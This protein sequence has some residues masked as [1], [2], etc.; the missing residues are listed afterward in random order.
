LIRIEPDWV[1]ELVGQWAGQDGVG[2]RHE[3]G[4]PNVSPMFSK[5][6]SAYVEDDVA[7]Y[8]HVELRAMVAA[9]DWLHLVHYE[10]WRALSREFRHWSRKTLVEKPGDRE[11]VLQA[12]RL[13]EKYIDEVLG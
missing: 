11:L 12:G 6:V 10:H 8:S 2:A 3:L 7:G 13:L 1:G 9:V 5:V 4:F